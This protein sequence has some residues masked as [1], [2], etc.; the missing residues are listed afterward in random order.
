MFNYNK[1]FR[2]LFIHFLVVLIILANLHELTGTILKNFQRIIKLRRFS[3]FSFAVISLPCDPNNKNDKRA[4]KI[5]ELK[6]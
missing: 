6:I 3:A 4:A 2:I 1:N 5:Q